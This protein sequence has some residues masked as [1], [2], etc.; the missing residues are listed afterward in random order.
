MCGAGNTWKIKPLPIGLP[1]ETDLKNF[2]TLGY[3]TVRQ[4]PN[5][6]IHI[7]ST[8]THP[9]LHYQIN[10]AWF[11][12]TDEDTPVS[13]FVSTSRSS[14][15]ASA[16]HAK[17][18]NGGDASWS[19]IVD[20][21]KG[22]LLDGAFAATFPNSSVVEYSASY[23]QGRRTSEAMRDGAGRL[24]WQWN[25]TQPSRSVFTKYDTS[26]AT[27]VRSEFEN[28]V[29]ARDY[30][31]IKSNPE[32]FRFIGLTADGPACIYHANGS[33]LAA[34]TFKA[35]VVTGTAACTAR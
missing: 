9:C 22:Y 34:N 25:H 2:G 35:G 11:H 12:A 14:A 10:E 6:V 16:V 31:L 30:H 1:H 27:R 24:L 29:A 17:T 8:M 13:D 3:S 19:Y 32:G 7:L 15:E 20:P 28:L 5:G 23:S 33:V 26:G 21:V 18:A 4:G